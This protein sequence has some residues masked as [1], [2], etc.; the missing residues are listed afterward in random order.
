M[1][2]VLWVLNSAYSYTGALPR[3]LR[4]SGVAGDGSAGDSW[5]W[6]E[7]AGDGWRCAGSEFGRT[8]ASPRRPPPSTVLP[9][10]VLR[11]ASNLEC[12]QPQGTGTGPGLQ[13]AS[14]ETMPKTLIC[15]FKRLCV[16]SLENRMCY[17]LCGAR[18]SPLRFLIHVHTASVDSRR[19]HA[20]GRR[21]RVR[22]MG[23]GQGAGHETTAPCPCSGYARSHRL[24]AIAA[25]PR[26]LRSESYRNS[27]I[28]SACSSGRPTLPSA[29]IAAARTQ[30]SWQGSTSSAAIAGR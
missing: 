8:R 17:L 13:L 10:L 14:K 9:L 20:R 28:T 21:T 15:F 1:V 25:A 18:L 30:A 23:E 3:L 26:R 27:V 29:S 4:S 6:L 11:S 12:Q 16:Y 2:M 22:H 5:R 24:S 19:L 7:M